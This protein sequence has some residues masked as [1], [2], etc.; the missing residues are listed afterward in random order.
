M[1]LNTQYL[2][3]GNIS[4]KRVIDGIYGL[5]YVYTLSSSGIPLSIVSS[6]LG[7]RVIAMKFVPNSHVGMG[8]EPQ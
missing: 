3:S 5:N 4:K 2:F 8:I 7:I 1:K 6:Q